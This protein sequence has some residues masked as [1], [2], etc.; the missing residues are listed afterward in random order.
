MNPNDQNHTGS[1]HAVKT[2]GEKGPIRRDCVTAG[3]LRF[4]THS[5][6]LPT[7]TQVKDAN[8]W[9]A[10][11]LFKLLHIFWGN[12]RGCFFTTTVDMCKQ[13]NG[14]A[15]WRSSFFYWSNE[16]H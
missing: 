1:T 2:C 8:N 5:F 15:E 11:C 16:A 9:L 3:H 6:T 14:S 12:R 13:Q 7:D 4:N 10:Q